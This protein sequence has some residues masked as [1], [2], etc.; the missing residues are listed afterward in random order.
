[1]DK[2]TLFVDK[3]TTLTYK[4]SQ[5]KGAV[6]TSIAAVMLAYALCAFAWLFFDSSLM[7]LLMMPVLF[8]IVGALH[9]FLVGRHLGML[10][11]AEQ[12]V[13]TLFVAATVLLLSSSSSLWELQLPLN[14]LFVAPS[15]F[16]LPFVLS[17][18]WRLY[19]RISYGGAKTWQPELDSDTEYPDIYIKGIQVRFR[20]IPAHPEIPR[21][22]VR[23]Q[24]SNKMVLG[25]VFIDMLQKQIKK[26]LPS[27]I[28]FPPGRQK[29][30]WVFYT[31]DKLL[32]KR[33]LDPDQSIRRNRLKE[34]KVIYAR[35][36]TEGDFFSADQQTF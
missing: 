12:W 23:F 9:V 36:V 10:T 34:K 33:T 20:V 31:R 8:I 17:Q 21:F 14:S 18:M 13:Y 2:E 1:M 27:E 29:D 11:I 7:V 30:E 24:A 16:L 28:L 5:Q 26:G 3:K 22:S 19:V 35:R 4:I 25:E 32:W 6:A 15:A